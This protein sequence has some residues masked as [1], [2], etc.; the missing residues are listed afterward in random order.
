MTSRLPIAI[1]TSLLVASALLLVGSLTLVGC[2]GGGTNSYSSPTA[3]TPTPAPGPTPNPSPDPT[4][5]NVTIAILGMNGALSYSPNPAT[6][7]VGQSVSWRN[8]DTLPHTATADG[9]AFA[10]ATLAPGAT[11]APIVMSVVG[12]YPYH[13]VIHGTTMTGTLIVVAAGSGGPGY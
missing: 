2:S 3:P 5:A 4:A 11:S 9:G 1:G 8:A 10:T 13:C 6:V 7:T 12:S